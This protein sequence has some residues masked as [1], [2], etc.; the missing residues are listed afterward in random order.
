MTTTRTAGLDVARGLAVLGTFATNVWVFTHPDG[1]L[2]TVL[3]PATSGPGSALAQVLPLGKSLALLSLLFGIG[4]ELQRRSALRRGAD[5]N[6]THRVRALVLFA[7]ASV[8]FL[9]IAEFDVLM[10]YAVAALFAAPVLAW[11][12]RTR[13]R[14]LTVLLVVHGLALGVLVVAL[15]SLPL[16]S[17]A[18]GG[19]D[20]PYATGSFADLVLFRLENLAVFRAEPVGLL[21]L[22]TASFLLGAGLVR[23]GIL[24][25][26]TTTRTDTGRLLRRRL[27]ALGAFGVVLEAV[28]LLVGGG[29]AVLLTRYGSAVLVALGVLALVLEVQ[30]RRPER[31]RWLGR[32]FAEVGRSALTCY[33]LQNLV[34]GLLCYGWGLGLATR[35]AAHRDTLTAVVY[36][37]V[38]LAVVGTAHLLARTGHRGPLE[39]FSA[40]AQRA[41]RPRAQQGVLEDASS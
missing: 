3:E 31:P 18:P 11:S 30:G 21:L 2:G 10:G 22:S 13:R 34:A 15:N 24:A 4:L 41:L 40:A 32:R 35:F 9:L 17:G 20:T 36:A 28:F 26:R 25:P 6:R 23:R 8:H 14:L 39:A 33:V 38:A 1:L 27:M 16:A 37:V 7:E 29:F 5:W 12:D 19:L